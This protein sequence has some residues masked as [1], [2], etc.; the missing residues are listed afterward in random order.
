MGLNLKPQDRKA[1][2]NF[3]SR[4]PVDSSRREEFNSHEYFYGSK[5]ELRTGYMYLG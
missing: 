3:I 2:R 5:R 4:A 1:E